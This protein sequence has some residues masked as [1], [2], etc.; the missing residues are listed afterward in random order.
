VTLEYYDV[1]SFYFRTPSNQDVA[2][3]I[4]ALSEGFKST[5]AWL[6]D[7]MLRIIERGGDI[8]NVHNI[9]GIV[10][11]DEIDLHLHPVW[12][13]KILSTLEQL[14]P[15]IQFIV[16]THSPFIV[17]SVGQ[18]NVLELYAR[19]ETQE[20]QIL[21]P[22]LP[23]EISYRATARE[24]FHIQSPFSYPIEQKMQKFQDIKT[25]LLKKEPVDEA[26]FKDLI[27][28]LVS[29]GV[30]VEGVLRREIRDLERHLGR[31]FGL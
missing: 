15:S 30:E 12:Q 14:F 7:M 5:F 1:E 4:E 3:P 9:S 19:R 31:E 24:L 11:L 28:E 22:R 21:P 23:V 25:A 8:D 20:V 29:K 27:E 6:L 16:T 18:G 17:Q 26:Q 13:R 10:L 2:I